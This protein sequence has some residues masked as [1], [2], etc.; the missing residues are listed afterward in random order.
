MATITVPSKGEVWESLYQAGIL[1][2]IDGFN[3]WTHRVDFR[4]AAGQHGEPCS[5]DLADFLQDY[6]PTSNVMSIRGVQKSEGSL[7]G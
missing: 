5:M 2:E 6:K 1:Q 3:E 7:G 4:P